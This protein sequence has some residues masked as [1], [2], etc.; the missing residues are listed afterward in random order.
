LRIAMLI[1]TRFPPEE[2]IGYYVYHLSEE[3]IKEGHEVTVITRGKRT[4]DH[5]TFNGIKV[6]KLPF[7]RF[8]PFHIWLHG[9]HVNRYLREH[10]NEFDL[11][12]IHSPLT[13]VP[14]TELPIVST[15]HTS[16]IG[17]AKHI[18]VIDLKSLLIKLYSPIF[19]K[20]II[21]KLLWVSRKVM[22]VSAAVS[23]ELR[24]YYH[25]ESAIVVGNGVS[26]E[27]FPHPPV[28]DRKEYVLYVGRLS[29]RKGVLDLIKAMETVFPDH[30]I[31]LIICG[32]GEMEKELARTIDEKGLKDKMEL[33]GHVE[34][35]EL[36]ELYYY[37]TMFVLPSHYEGLP[38]TLLEAMASG[39]PIISSDIPAVADL[40]V[41]K[42]NGLLFKTGNE[43]D[44]ASKIHIL[45][46][47]KDLSNAIGKE[48]RTMVFS[49]YSWYA[50]SEKVLRVYNDAINTVN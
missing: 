23:D 24:S 6:V 3:L 25:Y 18:E 33:I 43:E 30:N 13:P 39:T 38:T 2:G 16:V 32:K 46:S 47:D 40:I 44:L 31:K 45:Y 49:E 34:R 1:P 35:T 21:S 36:I 19:A 17:D 5:I 12:H 42:W 14:K 50:I 4:V 41:D 7:T 20:G 10:K 15:V 9:R 11:I 48:A 8:Y 28:K 27:E 37:A 22:T 26:I 29:Y